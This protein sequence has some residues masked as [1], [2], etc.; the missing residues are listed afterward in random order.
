M[1]AIQNSLNQALGSVAVAGR[2]IG[3]EKEQTINRGAAAVKE[4]RELKAKE[5]ELDKKIGEQMLA[6][7]NL[8][9]EQAGAAYPNESAPNEPERNLKLASLA[10]DLEV[11]RKALADLEKQ[12]AAIKAFREN[13]AEQIRQGQAWG[14]NY[15]KE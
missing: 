1:G 7:D 2:M 8:E 13:A 6:N 3:N 9:A 15:G 11:G 4:D 14:G 5:E 10:Y 12:Q